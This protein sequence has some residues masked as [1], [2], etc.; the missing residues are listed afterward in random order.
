MGNWGGERLVGD[1]GHEGIIVQELC[2]SRRSQGSRRD[3]KIERS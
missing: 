3:Q 1:G 2:E